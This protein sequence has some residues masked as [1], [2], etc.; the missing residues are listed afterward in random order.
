[1]TYSWNLGPTMVLVFPKVKDE[2][3]FVRGTEGAE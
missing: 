2:E 1:M 3:D